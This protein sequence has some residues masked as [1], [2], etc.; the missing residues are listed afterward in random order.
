MA[1]GNR[2]QHSVCIRSL[3]TGQEVTAS[4]SPPRHGPE[5]AVDGMASR[6]FSW[7]GNPAPQW[8][9]VTLPFAAEVASMGLVTDGDGSPYDPYRI[10]EFE[11]VTCRYMRVTVLENSANP[12]LHIMEFRAFPPLGNDGDPAPA[13]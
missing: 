8:L 6:S 5:N 13:Q 4:M 2:V 9:M 10:H 11:P 1:G 12:G 7:D 3:T